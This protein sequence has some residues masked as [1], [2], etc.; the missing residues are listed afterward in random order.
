[1]RK[2]VRGITP[3]YLVTA[4]TPIWRWFRRFSRRPRRW[5][6]VPGGWA[7]AGAHIRGWNV[8]SVLEAYRAKLPVFRQALVGPGPIGFP[9]S[10]AVPVGKPNIAEQN[11]VL[12]FAY[13]LSLAS[14]RK[15]RVTV[16]D[17]GGG[18][19]F[20]YLLSRALLPGDVAIEYH[21]KDGPL[22]CAYGREALPEINFW[23][24][25]S[26]LERQY[27]FVLASS[28][29]EYCER[30]T[31]VVARLANASRNYLF[32]TRMPVV[33]HSASFVGLVRTFGWQF[34]TEFLSWVFNRQE[35]LDAVSDSGMT[36]VREFLLHG[37]PLLDGAPEQYQTRA[38]LFARA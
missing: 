27:D 9:T 7:E 1:V 23:D 31:D 16:L 29:L 28:S 34:E 17:W 21:C 24:D 35:L 4:A 26:C 12:A 20:S 5:Q 8:D 15:D 18:L 13:S 14:R 3:P 22:I 11:T 10:A 25:E 2:L 37:R 32:L 36:L 19:G 33:L 6:F 38:Y 30:W